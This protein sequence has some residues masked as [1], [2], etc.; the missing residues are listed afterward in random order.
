MADPNPR[1]EDPLDS[2]A[3]K[4]L[5]IFALYCGFVLTFLVVSKIV[6][7]LVLAYTA[8]GQRFLDHQAALHVNPAFPAR[9][10]G[11]LA[12]ADAL[13]SAA[14]EWTLRGGADFRFLDGGLTDVRTVDPR[15][16]VNAAFYLPLD[17]GFGALASTFTW[18]DSGTGG[19]LGFD[20][21]FWDRDGLDVFDWSAGRAPSRSE[22]DVQDT[23]THELGHAL[24][25]GHSG[26]RYAT[27]SPFG[28]PGSTSAR[29]LHPDDQDG[30]RFLY[31]ASAPG[32]PLVTAVF[33]SE[34][35]L[36]GGGT[37]RVAGLGLLDATV[38]IDGEEAEPLESS[39]E[40]VTVLIPAGLSVGPAT[41]FV[42]GADGSES[43]VVNA[44]AYVE[45]AI[46]LAVSGTPAVGASIRLTVAGPSGGAFAIVADR[47]AGSGSFFGAPTGLALTA[48]ASAVTDSLFESV[49]R[50]PRLSASGLAEVPLELPDKPGIAH[51]TFLFQALAAEEPLCPPEAVGASRVVSVTILP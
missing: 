36:R 41:I 3:G 19:I 31:G 48:T 16:G 42:R 43:V 9:T 23:A 21:V 28:A 35:E 1:P 18:V 30:L 6:I 12:V 15:D 50:R 37:L 51:R 22:F 27:M 26:V 47:K 13:A 8:P 7:D 17:S 11:E 33:P 29:S 44:F 14:R 20:V 39:D 4:T 10:G 2:M 34:A 5:R 38:R 40:A 24:G 25:L 49:P 46:D 45:N 32:G